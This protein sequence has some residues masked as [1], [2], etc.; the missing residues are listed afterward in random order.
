MNRFLQKLHRLHED[1]TGQTTLEWALLMVGIGI[2]LIAVFA[3]L[4]ETIA[5]HYR[6]I[7]FL[8]MLPFP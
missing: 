4:L 3:L 6:A 5:V 7:S 8:Q 1:Q 2:P